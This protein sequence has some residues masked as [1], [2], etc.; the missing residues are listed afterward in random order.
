MLHCFDVLRVNLYILYAETIH[1]HEPINRKYG[2]HKAFLIEF[3][4]VLLRCAAMEKL[5]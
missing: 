4:N 5:N 3:V 1:E 2:T